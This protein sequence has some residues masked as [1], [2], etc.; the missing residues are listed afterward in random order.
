V[1]FCCTLGFVHTD[2]LVELAIAAEEGGWDCV[3]LADHVVNPDQI[4]ARYPYSATGERG[5]THETPWPDVW[6]ATAAMAAHTR[7]LRFS[8]GVYVLPMRDPFS[9][10]K[11][12]GTCA[13]MS[14][15]RVSLGIGL[16]WMSDEFELLGH[17]FADRA[18]RADEM[19][20]VIRLLWSGKLVEHHGRFYD[21]GPLSMSP[22]VDGKIP[23][24][25]G[26]WSKPALRR[27]A[28]LGDG[29]A[30]AYLKVAEVAAAIAEIRRM[31]RDFGRE[32]AALEVY[33]ACPDARDL[34]GYRRMQD[35][36]ISHVVTKPWAL[37][38][39]TD[40]LGIAPLAAMKDGLRRFSDEVIARFA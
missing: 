12:A 16:G 35:A 32:S 2:H 25:V 8:Q 4:T 10:A 6:V 22:G 11:A 9:V 21:F 15:H 13:R 28:R 7:R 5:W 14:G 36:G 31:Q 17:A 34:D 29:W 27:V 3:T 18:A 19:V 24:I 38:G 40:A 33:A 1:K 30:P 39:K 37:Y 26:G 20:A 23:I